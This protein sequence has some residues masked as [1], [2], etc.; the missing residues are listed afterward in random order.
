MMTQR[1]FSFFPI[2]GF[3]FSKPQIRSNWVTLVSLVSIWI[4]SAPFTPFLNDWL[5]DTNRQ[6]SI[7]LIWRL[8]QEIGGLG[9]AHRLPLARRCVKGKCELRFP[10]EKEGQRGRGQKK[11]TLW[12]VLL[13]RHLLVEEAQP[14][15]NSSWAEIPLGVQRF[16]LPFD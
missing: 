10:G 13:F 6:P 9:V 7:P 16:L 2:C 15:P 1:I 3:P 12:M 11:K 14:G 8:N 5:R 4:S